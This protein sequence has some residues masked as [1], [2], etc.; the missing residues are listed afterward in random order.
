MRL[1][2]WEFR[3]TIS[4]AQLPHLHA[5]RSTYQNIFT[6]VPTDSNDWNVFLALS[7]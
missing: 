6:F 1:K 2:S 7:D 5:C 4:L 3:S